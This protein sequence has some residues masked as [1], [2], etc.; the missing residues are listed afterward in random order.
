MGRMRRARSERIDQLIAAIRSRRAVN[1]MIDGP[2]SGI[3]LAPCPLPAP[4]YPL[5]TNFYERH[6]P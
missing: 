3:L 2:A 5:A 4:L 1:D 6:C